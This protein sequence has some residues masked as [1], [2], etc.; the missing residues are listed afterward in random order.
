VGKKRP[1]YTVAHTTPHTTLHS[2]RN[3]AALRQ[4]KHVWGPPPP[5]QLFSRRP[6]D[7]PTMLS[8]KKISVFQPSPLKVVPTSPN[9]W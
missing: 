4:R 7:P 5:L 8:R 6:V 2:N 1:C 9:A 3:R